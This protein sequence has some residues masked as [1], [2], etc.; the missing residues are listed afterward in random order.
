Q[1]VNDAL[2]A[3]AHRQ[4]GAG[5]KDRS[6]G[7]EVEIGVIEKS[8]VAGREIVFDREVAVLQS[9]LDEAVAVVFAALIGV[10]GAIARNEVELAVVVGGA[11]S[12]GLPDAA[13]GPGGRRGPKSHLLQRGRVVGE[14]VT[15]TSVAPEGDVHRAFAEKKARPLLLAARIEAPLVVARI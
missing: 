2:F 7:A 1:K 15:A 10:E 8:L 3:A 6:A 11:A 5:E 12:T 14:D 13:V 9:E 4:R